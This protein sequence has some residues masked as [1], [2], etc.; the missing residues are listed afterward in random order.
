MHSIKCVRSIASE[1]DSATDERFE[2]KKKMQ[3]AVE[4]PPQQQGQGYSPQM[5]PAEQ[6]RMQMETEATRPT[7]KSGWL[8][9][10]IWV[11]YVS[12]LSVNLLAWILAIVFFLRG[13]T[14]DSANVGTTYVI[15]I[16]SIIGF[17]SLLSWILAIVDFYQAKITT[18]T[19]YGQIHPV[20]SRSFLFLIASVGVLGV[21]GDI[22]VRDQTNLKP[23]NWPDAVV[24]EGVVTKNQFALLLTVGIYYVFNTFAVYY[25][26][27]MFW[28]WVFDS[29]RHGG[30]KSGA[31]AAS[32]GYAPYH[33]QP[34]MAGRAG[35][36]MATVGVRQRAPVRDTAELGAPLVANQWPRNPSQY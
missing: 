26:F 31:F 7:G 23:Y 15:S 21:I 33:A 25:L 24:P 27:D 28:A 3:P 9:V 19:S 8:R 1:K 34:R 17:L 4:T 11:A 22:M 10:F 35:V 29:R 5:S 32:R 20:A 16:A 18:A 14:I 30:Y 12:M 6:Q 13:K 2:K 36:P